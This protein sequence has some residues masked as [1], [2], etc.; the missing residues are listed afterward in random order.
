[1]SFFKQR[2]YDKIFELLFIHIIPS[3]SIKIYILKLK[4][5]YSYD[6]LYNGKL[7]I[8]TLKFSIKLFLIRI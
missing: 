5:K 8:I 2:L 3:N 1:M 7:K 6:C 4:L